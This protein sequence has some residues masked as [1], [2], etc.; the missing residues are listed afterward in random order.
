MKVI[1]IK[2]DG[3]KIVSKNFIVAFKSQNEDEK[4]IVA[5]QGLTQQDILAEQK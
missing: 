2:D 4:D 1:L 3:S 5:V